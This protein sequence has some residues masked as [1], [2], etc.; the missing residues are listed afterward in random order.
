MNTMIGT[1]G[2]T[3]NVVA[4]LIGGRIGFRTIGAEGYRVRAVPSEGKTFPFPAGW[5]TPGDEGQNRYSIVARDLE[6]LAKAIS[7]AS[8]LFSG[9]SATPPRPL[10]NANVAGLQIDEVEDGGLDID[11]S[12]LHRSDVVALVAALQEYLTV[13]Q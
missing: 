5:K 13:S 6:G 9:G 7:V 12:E 11:G 8:A 10:F 2:A 3:F 4:T 1:S